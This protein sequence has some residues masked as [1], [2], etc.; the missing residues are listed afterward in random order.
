MIA[1]TARCTVL[2][3]GY[4]GAAWG[5]DWCS[6]LELAV[7]FTGCFGTTSMRWTGSLWYRKATSVG[8]WT[9]TWRR[10]GTLPSL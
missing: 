3:P 8:N 10:F 5:E 1:E 4:V 7:G 6:W 2:C 9:R